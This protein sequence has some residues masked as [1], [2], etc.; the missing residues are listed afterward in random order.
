MSVGGQQELQDRLLSWDHL[1]TVS[2]AHK[3]ESGDSRGR[4]G[5]HTNREDV[6]RQPLTPP[7]VERATAI[8][9]IQDITPSNFSPK[10]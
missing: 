2:S 3:L 8:G 1:S 5:C 9:M 4:S 10:V 6:K 7:K